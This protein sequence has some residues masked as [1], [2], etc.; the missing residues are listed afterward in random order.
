MDVYTISKYN[1]IVC[2]YICTYIY[3]YDKT[4]TNIISY[5]NIVCHVSMTRYGPLVGRGWTPLQDRA[6][7]GP[8]DQDDRLRRVDC[9]CPGFP[10]IS[11]GISHWSMEVL[12][13][14]NGS[15]NGKIFKIIYKHYNHSS[16]KIKWLQFHIFCRKSWLRPLVQA[17]STG[18]GLWSRTVLVPVHQR[19]TQVLVCA[20]LL[21]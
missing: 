2:K 21:H 19:S 8:G 12:M 16:K 6:T 14:I 18:A 3:I 11:H 9:R 13:G 1:Y 17:A 20:T 7:V 5:V 10:G 4:F 15:F